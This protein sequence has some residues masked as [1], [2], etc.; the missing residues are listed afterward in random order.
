MLEELKEVYGT[1]CEEI[2]LFDI[3]VKTEPLET[4]VPSST[5]EPMSKKRTGFFD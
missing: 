1:E 4:L 5:L 2:L 3:G